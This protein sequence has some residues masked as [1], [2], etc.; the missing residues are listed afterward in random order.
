MVSNNTDELAKTLRDHGVSPTTQR[1]R[2]AELVL[3]EPSHFTADQVF[4]KVSLSGGG[5]SRATVY[6]TLSLFLDKH[7]LSEVIV[8][9]GKLFYDSTTEPHHHIYD[10]E[11]GELIDIENARVSVS[12]LPPLPEGK[13]VAGIN[14][15]VRIRTRS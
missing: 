10:I 13:E 4:E 14:A 11:S 6:N 8:D 7:L 12:G 5:V 9:P 15:V 3:V 1:V 2:I